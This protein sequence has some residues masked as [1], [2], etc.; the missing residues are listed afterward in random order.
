MPVTKHLYG[1]ELSLG[2]F[3]FA[4]KQGSATSLNNL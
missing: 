4:Q 3:S 1:A 2:P